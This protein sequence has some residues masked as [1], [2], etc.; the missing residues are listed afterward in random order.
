MHTMADRNFGRR[1]SYCR[2][3]L[4]GTLCSVP[5]PFYNESNKDDFILTE[6]CPAKSSVHSL[7]YINAGNKRSYHYTKGVGS[8]VVLITVVSFTI[9][10]IIRLV[11]KILA[12]VLF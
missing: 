6:V 11:F 7:D 4:Y 3:T 10:N 8:R 5:S 12:E 2:N 1:S 9:I